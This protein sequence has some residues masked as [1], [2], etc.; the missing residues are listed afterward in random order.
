MPSK[1]VNRK[2]KPK[3]GKWFQKIFVAT[4]AKVVIYPVGVMNVNSK[5][6]PSIKT[7]NS[8]LN[9]MIIPARC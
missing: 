7:W 8:V 2:N 1:M 5:I 4:D 3:S 6:A 9:A